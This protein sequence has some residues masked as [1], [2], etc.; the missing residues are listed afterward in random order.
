MLCDQHIVVCSKEAVQMMSTVHQRLVP[1]FV[2]ADLYKPT[3]DNHPCTQ[4]VSHSAKHYAWLS[5]HTGEM[6]R[7]YT[8]RFGK[9][10]KSQNMFERVSDVPYA[11]ADKTLFFE[12]PQV[13]PAQYRVEGDA[14][15]AYRR[16]YIAEK[17]AFARWFHSEPPY[18]CAQEYERSRHGLP[19]ATL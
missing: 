15:A 16:Y 19:P 13:M 1:H 4:W 12:P 8:R 7:E 10:H 17:L 6:F 9:R 2:M 14:V 18:W 5:L 11:L 3:H